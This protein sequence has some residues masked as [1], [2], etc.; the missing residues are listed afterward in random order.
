MRL[1]IIFIVLSNFLMSDSF[2]F[3]SE[4]ISPTLKEQMINNGSWRDGCPV[5]I[6]D[7]R[8][9]K[10]SYIDF[11]GKINNNGHLIVHRKVVSDIKSIFKTLFY[12]KF[13]IQKMQLVSHNNY[14][15]SD[16]K[17]MMANNTSAFNCRNVY[18]SK[19]FSKH[20]YG[21]AIDINPVQ[22]PCVT[23]NRVSPKNGVR[24]KNRTKKFKGMI[25]KN[26]NTYKLFKK[27]GWQWGGEWH[28]LKDYQ[29]F[30]KKPF[31]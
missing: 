7:L 14:K 29:H 15:S 4:L 10:L 28:S 22:N 26:D 16:D 17:S 27:Y 24:Y 21:I 3:K 30:V 2:R 12:N 13:K 9:I 18:K 8:Y 23:G 6:K 20:S 19:K 25:Q 1:I 31:I 5:A 11:N